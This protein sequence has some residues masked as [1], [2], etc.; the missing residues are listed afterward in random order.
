MYQE[1]AMIAR[2][3]TKTP[4]L[5][6][7]T[8]EEI[9]KLYPLGHNPRFEFAPQGYPFRYV[10]PGTFAPGSNTRLE[11]EVHLLGPETGNRYQSRPAQLQWVFTVSRPEPEPTTA[12]GGGTING[13]TESQGGNGGNGGNENTTPNT[14]VGTSRIEAAATPQNIAATPP[15]TTTTQPAYVAEVTETTE[16][17]EETEGYE[18]EDIPDVDVPLV[19]IDTGEEDGEYPEQ[20]NNA[21]GH[22]SAA[23][24][25]AEYEEF[26][27][28][29]VPLAA[30]DYEMPKTGELPLWY[31]VVAGLGLVAA[32]S[33]AAVRMRIGDR[34]SRKSKKGE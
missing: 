2:F 7:F 25:E 13:N 26:P 16:E 34:K 27:D 29:P 21:D 23:E 4:D 6:A 20:P 22:M 15:E 24:D 5:A 28:N 18:Y 32:G 33:G 8:D 31:N 10:Y 30:G 1:G 11:F 14:A 9:D 12:G 3:G 19:I 17:T